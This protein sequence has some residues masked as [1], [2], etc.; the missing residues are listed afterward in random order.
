[1]MHGTFESEKTIHFHAPENVPEP[2]AWGT[3]KS[4]PDTHF[5]ICAFHD[6]LEDLPDARSLGELISRITLRLKESPLMGN[7]GFKSLHT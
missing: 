3:Y 6:M 7:M 2:I 1:M 4:Q 5:Y